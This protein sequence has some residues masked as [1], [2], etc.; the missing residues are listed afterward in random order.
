MYIFI[1]GLFVV[2]S[3][4]FVVVCFHGR[5]WQ[6][7]DVLQPSWLIVPPALDVPTFGHQM[8]PRLPTRSALQRR[9]LELMGGE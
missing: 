6:V 8:P 9:K 5:P 1:F 3:C 4:L 2:V 7:T